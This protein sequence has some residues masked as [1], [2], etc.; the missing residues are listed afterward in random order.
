MVGDR[1]AV[2][3]VADA[4]EQVEALAGPRQDHR[5]LLAGHPDLLEPLGQA[6]QRDVV[7]AE[8]VEGALGGRHLGR[9]AVDDDQARAR[10]RTCGAGRCRGRRASAA[11][12]GV[13]L[14]R[15]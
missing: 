6:A 14:A 3:L 7:D 1:E 2:G 9:P 8:L 11:L 12:V 4:L 10:R 5:V 15:R 13:D